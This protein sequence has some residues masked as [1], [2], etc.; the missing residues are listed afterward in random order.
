MFKSGKKGKNAM[1]KLM[2]VII[3][4]RNDVV[5]KDLQ[6]YTKKENPPK[7]ISV[8]YG[9][10][11]MRGLEDSIV[12]KMGYK[13]AGDEWLTVY[14]VD[15]KKTGMDKAQLDMIKNMIKMQMDNM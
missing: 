15:V 7:S 3:D 5:I 4:E 2:G 8:F 1:D 12:S 13:P 10:G 11:H 6:K 14:T 9:A